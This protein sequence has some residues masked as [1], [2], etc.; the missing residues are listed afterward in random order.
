MRKINKYEEVYIDKANLANEY[1]QTYQVKYRQ[2]VVNRQL[3]R[4]S[5]NVVLEVGCG[6]DSQFFHLKRIPSKYIIVEPGECFYK[7][8]KDRISS[9]SVIMYNKMLENCKNELKKYKFDFIIIGSLLHEIEDARL[10]LEIVKEIADKETIIHI[11]VPNANSFH[12]LLAVESGLIEHTKIMSQR[13]LSMQQ[14]HIFDMNELCE[15]IETNNGIVLDKGSYAFKP[16]SHEQM[17]QIVKSGIIS[18]QVLDGFNRCSR[19]FGEYG[20]EIFVNFRFAN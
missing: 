18:E 5:P 13:N 17:M 6:L 7:E 14:N 1:E 9:A 12:R 10:F 8:V 16:F 3:E 4:Y 11:N 19:Y 15:L 2:Q 20:S